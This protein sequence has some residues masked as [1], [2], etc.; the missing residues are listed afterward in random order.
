MARK[1]GPVALLLAAA[2]ELVFRGIVLDSWGPWASAISFGA[3]HLGNV[4]ISLSPTVTALSDRQIAAVVQQ[5][6]FAL[7][8]GIYANILTEND[9][10]RLGKPIAVHYWNNVV[11]MV[12]GYLAGDGVAEGRKPP[13]HTV[14]VTLPRYGPLFLSS[15]SRASTSGSGLRSR[16]RSRLATARGMSFGSFS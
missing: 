3:L 2:E 7:S 9:G 8:F 16:E 5:S 11:S 14:T 12:L 1:I 4:F 10:N 15:S 6:A 13:R